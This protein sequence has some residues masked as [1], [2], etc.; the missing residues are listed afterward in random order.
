MNFNEVNVTG[1]YSK[2]DNYT[3]ILTAVYF[4]LKLPPTTKVLDSHVN[5]SD[6]TVKSIL[7]V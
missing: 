7:L 2:S 1:Q 5:H 3:D 4:Y 6:R